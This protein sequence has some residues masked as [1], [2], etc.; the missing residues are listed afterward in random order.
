MTFWE[1]RNG[2]GWD[3]GGG[4]THDGVTGIG[5]FNGYTIMMAMSVNAAES[6][7]GVWNGSPV[8]MMTPRS[9]MARRRSS[10]PVARRT[11]SPA[12]V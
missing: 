3:D 5:E 10:M 11:L 7:N 8:P 12:R 4:W 1:V 2:A 6:Y 9:S